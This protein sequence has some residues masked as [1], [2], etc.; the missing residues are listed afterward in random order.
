MNHDED[1]MF[2]PNQDGMLACFFVFYKLSSRILRLNALKH[3]SKQLWRSAGPSP[4]W[5]KSYPTNGHPK[6]SD[7]LLL[8]ATPDETNKTAPTSGGHV[9]QALEFWDISQGWN[10]GMVGG[11]Q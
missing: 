1:P 3:N 5:K 11:V 4:G 6:V 8:R 9:N 10:G 2:K 7:V